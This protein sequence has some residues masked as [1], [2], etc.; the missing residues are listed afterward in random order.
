MVGLEAVDCSHH[1]VDADCRVRDNLP[2]R[3]GCHLCRLEEHH[4]HAESA[5]IEVAAAGIRTAD[6][7]VAGLE[8]CQAAAEGE[9]GS[10]IAGCQPLDERRRPAALVSGEGRATVAGSG[11]QC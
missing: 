7:A 4:H 10:C 6:A 5:D 11:S 2:D 8:D 3:L 9:E 1:L